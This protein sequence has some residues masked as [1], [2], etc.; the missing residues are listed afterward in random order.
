MVKLKAA[1]LKMSSI[2]FEGHNLKQKRIFIKKNCES[3]LLK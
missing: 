2:Y 3:W 1:E